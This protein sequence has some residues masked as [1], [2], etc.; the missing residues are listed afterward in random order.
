MPSRVEGFGLA[1]PEAITSGTPVLISGASGLGLLLDRPLSQD[2]PEMINRLV[3]PVRNG[4]RHEDANVDDWRI[5]IT[6]A[7]GDLDAAFADAATVR[8]ALAEK[9]TWAMAATRLLEELKR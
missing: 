7:L 1:G 4:R 8:S 6:V 5:A 9:R 2:M 3:V